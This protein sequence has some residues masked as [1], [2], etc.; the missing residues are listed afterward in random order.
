MARDDRISGALKR[1][2][3]RTPGQKDRDRVLYSLAFRRL[4]TV[5]QVVGPLE[6]YIFHNRLT[7]TLEVAQIGRRLAEL[8]R[9]QFPTANGYIDPDVVECAAMAHDLGHPPFGHAA[10]D[11]LNRIAHANGLSDGFEGNAQ[12]FRII[13]RLA[14]LGPRWP[15]GLD[16]TRASL[17]AVLKYPWVATKIPPTTS[18]HKK[19]KFGA[20]ASDDVAFD[21]ARVLGPAAF[22][23]CPEAQIMDLAD[24]IAY[25]VHDVDDFYRAGLLPLDQLATDRSQFYDFLARWQQQGGPMIAM[26]EMRQLENLLG[27]VRLGLPYSGTRAQRA[28]LRAFTSTQIGNF[29]QAV[30]LQSDPTCVWRVEITP[31]RKLDIQFLKQLVW[32]FVITNPRLASLQTGQRRIIR[33]L[34]TIYHDAI[35]HDQLDVIPPLFREEAESLIAGHA[36]SSPDAVRLAI[37]IVASFGDEQ[38]TKMAHRLTGIAVGSVRDALGP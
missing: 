12:S 24:D 20:Y 4:A 30:T 21:F 37:D 29:V 34:F 18:P 2:Q 26:P 13:T 36:T 14:E 25:S 22:E 28:G 38:A 33:E 27:L 7:H 23:Q 8:L 1:Q 15:N 9:A 32:D 6:G 10:E 19:G 35:N 11:E 5:T 16:L 31:A 17:N 3:Q